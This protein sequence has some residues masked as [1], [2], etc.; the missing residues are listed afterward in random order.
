VNRG[1]RVHERTTRQND[2]TERRP[3]EPIAHIGI[4]V[5][6]VIVCEV[7]GG[8]G[9]HWRLSA[10]RHRRLGVLTAMPRPLKQRR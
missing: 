8:V 9:S 7:L 5:R 2:C 10:R 4:G 6:D 3:P 1:I